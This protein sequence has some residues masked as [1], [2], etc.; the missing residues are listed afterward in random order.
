[1][2]YN[3]KCEMCK[4]DSHCFLTYLYTTD[5]LSYNDV[6]ILDNAPEKLGLVCIQCLN[7]NQY[8]KKW[9]YSFEFTDTDDIVACVQKVY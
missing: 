2:D 3:T 6:R 5:V 4:Q 7:K 8:S 1:M 9:K